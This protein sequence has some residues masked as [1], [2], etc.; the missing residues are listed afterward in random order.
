[1]GPPLLLGNAL[2]FKDVIRCEWYISEHD[3]SIVFAKCNYIN[4]KIES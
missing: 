1:M 3:W 4:T 2:N